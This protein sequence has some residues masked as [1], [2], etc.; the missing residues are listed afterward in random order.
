MELKEA[1]KA[2]GR[3]CREPI[4]GWYAKVDMDGVLCWHVVGKGDRIEPVAYR[5]YFFDDWRPCGRLGAALDILHGTRKTCIECG[6][7]DPLVCIKCGE[8]TQQ[9]V[10]ERTKPRGEDPE[11][12][13]RVQFPGPQL[14][15]RG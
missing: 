14:E 15:K 10:G 5:S 6:G 11:M 13:K 3:A 9:W 7:D 8:E 1:M 2:S 4:K 12:G